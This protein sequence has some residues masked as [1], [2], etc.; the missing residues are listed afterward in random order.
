MT[1][2]NVVDMLKNRGVIDDGVAYDVA[3]EAAE[4]GKE[5]QQVLL[6]FGV[7]SNED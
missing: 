6:D 5:V 4:S 1:A 7:F 2:Q 3:H